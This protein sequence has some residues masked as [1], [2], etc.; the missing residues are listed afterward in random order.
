MC[1]IPRKSLQITVG[2]G[3]NFTFFGEVTFHVYRR[4]V[5]SLVFFQ[6][7]LHVAL[8][9]LSSKMIINVSTLM[10]ACR[11]G[12]LPQL[13]CA[14]VADPPHDFPVLDFVPLLS[15]MAFR[16]PC[17]FAVHALTKVEGHCCR[18]NAPHTGLTLTTLANIA[19]VTKK[20]SNPNVNTNG[21]SNEDDHGHESHRKRVLPCRCASLTGTPESHGTHVLTCR[22][23]SLPDTPEFRL[24]SR[25]YMLKHAFCETPE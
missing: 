3:H 23:T 15:F 25:A 9:F 24:E 11:G 5:S 17:P 18:W 14:T 8:E 2:R 1:P 19:T 12:P 22:H 20:S 10:D 21:N 7:R 13:V 4:W 16:S 6:T